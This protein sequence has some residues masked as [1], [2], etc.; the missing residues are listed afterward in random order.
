MIG[1][2]RP[3]IPRVFIKTGAFGSYAEVSIV[4]GL[5]PALVQGVSADSS[6]ITWNSPCFSSSHTNITLP[7]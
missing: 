7:G 3:P 1:G 6:P 2:L 4:L 5:N